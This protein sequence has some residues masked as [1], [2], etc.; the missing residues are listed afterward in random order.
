MGW[1]SVLPFLSLSL[2]PPT[3]VALTR[4]RKRAG[5]MGRAWAGYGYERSMMELMSDEIIGDASH[6]GR[7]GMEMDF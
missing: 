1:R 7:D 5:G 4:K 3:E 6:Q 2:A